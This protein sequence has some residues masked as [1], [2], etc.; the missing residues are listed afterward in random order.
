MEKF[1]ITGIAG[2]IGS[3][4]AEMLLREGNVVIGIDNLSGPYPQSIYK[5]NLNLLNR[6]PHFKF[7]QLDILNSLQV[8]E[9]FSKNNYSY[10]FHC[11]AKTNVRDSF[12]NPRL[13]FETNVQGTKNILEA[14]K[15]Y[16]PKT[17]TVLFSSS[18]VY[19]KQDI[20]FFTETIQPNPISPYGISKYEMEELGKQYHSRWNIPL[21]ILRL[22]SV[23]GPRGRLDMAPFLTIKAAESRVPFVQ[24]GNDINNRRDWTYIKDV[25]IGI[26]QIINLQPFNSLKIINIARG[27][28]IGI[29]EFTNIA[30]KIIKKILNE[31]LLIVN[32]PRNKN[33]MITTSASISFAKKYLKFNPKVD[34][35]LGLEIMVKDYLRKRN[36]YG[37]RKTK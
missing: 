26:K 32:R 20:P 18:S 29:G 10:V 7:I 37:F 24:F 3:H 30:K 31:D 16:Q 4:I 33:E 36:I 6:H 8:N 19:G 17:R 35:E 22:F 27:K 1:L 34:F 5:Y 25:V 13:Y 23:Y 12:I 2:F 9:I 15:R 28:S 11:A 21:I 14:I